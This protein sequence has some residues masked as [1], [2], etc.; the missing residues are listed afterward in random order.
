MHGGQVI[1]TQLFMP[2]SFYW[3]TQVGE[4]GEY[5]VGIFRQ[6]D[7]IPPRFNGQAD[8]G[9]TVFSMDSSH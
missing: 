4:T 9:T 8:S 6:L 2:S 3:A 5:S 1:P 7:T